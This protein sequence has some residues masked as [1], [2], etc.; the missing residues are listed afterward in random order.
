MRAAPIVL[1]VVALGGSGLAQPRIPDPTYIDAAVARAE[2]TIGPCGRAIE[3]MFDRDA[4]DSLAWSAAPRSRRDTQVV[5]TGAIGKLAEA[6]LHVC[7]NPE[8]HP[9]LA[10]FERVVYRPVGDRTGRLDLRLEGT[11]LIAKEDVF[12]APHDVAAFEVA[13]RAL[14]PPS[15]AWDGS[16]AFRSNRSTGNSCFRADLAGPLVVTKGAFQFFW[17]ADDWRAPHTK[18]TLTAGRVD[19]VVHADGTTTTTVAFTH[20]SLHDPARTSL[21]HALGAITSIDVR[22]GARGKGTLVTAQV[23]LPSGVD[24]GHCYSEWTGAAP[25]VAQAPRSKP[26]PAPKAPAQH[27]AP[28]SEP[29]EPKQPQADHAAAGHCSDDCET[30]GRICWNQ[31]RLTQQSCVENCADGDGSCGD[32]C[33]YGEQDCRGGCSN[34]A[35]ACVARCK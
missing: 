14:A 7:R 15:A 25:P 5:V 9:W 23:D 28:P 4:F 31:C 16:Y 27:K 10:T 1:L 34:T 33:R 18:A 17:I 21:A 2:D 24:G 12:G 32:R 29:S 19:G 8:L 35:R 11:T 30:T 6:F 26:E 20:S 13:L 22:F 3:V